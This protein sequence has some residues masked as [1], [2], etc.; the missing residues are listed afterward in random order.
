MRTRHRRCI[1]SIVRQ[2]MTFV[3]RDISDSDL[4]DVIRAWIDVLR[5]KNYGC[6]FEALGYSMAGAAASPGIVESDLSRYRSEL[7]EGETSF[8]V[9]DWRTASGGNPNPRCEVEWFERNSVGLAGAATFDLPLNGRWSD[10]AAD[11]ILF[12][13]GADEGLVLKLEELRWP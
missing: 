3:R 10:L 5:D 4:L 6:F 12:E 2:K 1:H 13:T 9:T 8:A 7:F 11:R